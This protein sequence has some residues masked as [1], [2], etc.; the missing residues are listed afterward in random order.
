MII[1]KLILN[2][3]VEFRDRVFDIYSKKT[4]SQ[5]G[6]DM[7][8]S[9]I[10]DGRKQSFYVDIGAHHPRRFSNTYFFL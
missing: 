7:I 3:L 2:R 6:E 4:Y 5:E 9:R 1:N 8:L 10:F